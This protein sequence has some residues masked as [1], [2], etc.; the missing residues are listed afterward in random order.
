MARKFF[1]V[2]AGLFMLSLSYHLG[3]RAAVAQVGPSEHSAGAFF[4][5]TG[6]LGVLTPNGDVFTRSMDGSGHMV[7]GA[8]V[9]SGNFWAGPTAVTPSTLG[10]VK[11]TYR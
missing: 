9:Y 4:T 5:G 6:Y 1:Y 3:A 10:R 7:D 11:A 2:C 8:P